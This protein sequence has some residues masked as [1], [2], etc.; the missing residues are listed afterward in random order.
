LPTR[1]EQIE[2]LVSPAVADLGCRLVRVRLSGGQWPTL[3]IMAERA[4]GE[5]ISVEICAQISRSIAAILEVEDPISGP[6]NLEVSSPGLDR[7]L[8]RGEDFVR[9][10]GHEALIQTARLIAGRRRF[11]GELRGVV[12]EVVTIRAGENDVEI[13]LADIAEAQLA[14]TDAL[15]AESLKRGDRRNKD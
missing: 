5:D 8:V 2:R 1:T 10:E 4:D 15:I 11:R 7:P 9:F 12:G 14:Q 3:Q 13:A 6:Y